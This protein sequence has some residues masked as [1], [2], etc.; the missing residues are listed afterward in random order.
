MLALSDV[1]ADFCPALLD[2]TRQN[3]LNCATSNAAYGLGGVDENVEPPKMLFDPFDHPLNL[4][5]T[6][7]ARLHRDRL[8]I[9]RLID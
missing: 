1:F 9:S 4:L 5:F 8:S 3:W 2:I 7:N 6:R